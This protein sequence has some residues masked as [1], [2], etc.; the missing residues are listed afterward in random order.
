M[1]SMESVHRTDL[2]RLEALDDLR[3]LL[4]KA[5]L[6]TRWVVQLQGLGGAGRGEHC[7]RDPADRANA[8]RNAEELAR[9]T[10][11]VAREAIDNVASG[12]P[13]KLTDLLERVTHYERRVRALCQMGGLH[14]GNERLW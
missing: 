9:E 14:M 13:R 11:S 8:R 2:A 6:A 10:S 5:E 3:L 7:L 12:H 1:D 4:Q